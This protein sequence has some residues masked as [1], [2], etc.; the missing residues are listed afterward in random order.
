MAAIYREISTWSD[1]N[2]KLDLW[3]IWCGKHDSIIEIVFQAT[4]FL[5]TMFC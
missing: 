3:V 1:F 5:S 4:I 2:E